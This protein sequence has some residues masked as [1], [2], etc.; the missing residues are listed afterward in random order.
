MTSRP[1][2]N[3]RVLNQLGVELGLENAT[4]VLRMFITD[5]E[6][7]IAVMTSTGASRLA[8]RREAHSIKSSAATLGFERLSW[9]AQ[10]L[11]SAAETI[12]EVQLESA[13]SALQSA[14]KQ[15]AAFAEHQL[16][17]SL[18]ELP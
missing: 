10:E 16:L 6:Q 14:F 18:G 15:M 13:I 7:K 5:T 3:A 1:I 12:D 9:L 4:D 11:E 17:S 8:T 2:L